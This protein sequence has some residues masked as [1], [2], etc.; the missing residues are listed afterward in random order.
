MASGWLCLNL[1]L[2]WIS[3]AF[4]GLVFL[5]CERGFCLSSTDA[6]VWCK[7]SGVRQAGGSSRA[8]RGRRVT[9][10]SLPVNAMS[11]GALL[12]VHFPRGVPFARGDQAGYST[13]AVLIASDGSLFGHRILGIGV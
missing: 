6:P 9:A 8:G 5:A 13:V 11:P 1:A 2:A 3:L 12:R 7:R 10:A 4:V